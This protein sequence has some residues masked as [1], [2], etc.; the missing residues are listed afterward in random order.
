VGSAKAK[1]SRWLRCV[2]V[3][4]W[5]RVRPVHISVLLIGL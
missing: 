1:D 3:S 2:E 5:S 4:I